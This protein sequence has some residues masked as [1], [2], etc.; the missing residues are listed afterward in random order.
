MARLV[1]LLRCVGKAALRNSGRAIA[2]L[3]PLGEVGFDIARDAC[4][5]FRKDPV[6]ARQTPGR[7]LRE[8]APPVRIRSPNRI[9]RLVCP[10]AVGE[11]T[12]LHFASS[13]SRDIAEPLWILNMAD[14]AQG[15][16]ALEREREVQAYLQAQ[17]GATTYRNYL[18]LLEESFTPSEG[19]ARR[20]NVF[21][22]EP[23]FFTLEQVHN[24]HPS[25][26]GRHLAWIF[27][28][29]LTV[30]GF[31]HTRG[32]LHGS[33]LPTQVLIHA[34]NHGLRLVNWGQS[35]Q[36]GQPIGAYSERYRDWYPPEV[37]RGLAASTASD[38]FLAARCMVYLSGGDAVRNRMPEA[39]PA[40]LRRFFEGC[41]LAGVTMR[42]HDAWALLEEFD[43]L[44]RR[45]YGPPEFHL[46][47]LN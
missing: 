12:C 15:R 2:S 45:L 20:V 31:C 7:P 21:A 40:P 26:D 22:H 47:T 33:I 18:P 41:L 5:E 10:L 3:V 37:Q 1:R 27:K 34:G 14:S 16:I 24:Q 42:P 44:L 43:E 39:V 35:L 13:D 25:L 38:L 9:Y 8:D 28:R 32:I 6:D 46:L 23:G 4:L 30:L 36:I 17:A 11:V 19:L 29:L